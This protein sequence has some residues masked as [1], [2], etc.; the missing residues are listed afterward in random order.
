M[1][2]TAQNLMANV[3]DYQY[4]H[5]HPVTHDGYS[6]P[7][8]PFG[9]SNAQHTYSPTDHNGP[10]SFYYYSRKKEATSSST[11]PS[12]DLLDPN[13]G[14]FE[15]TLS[16]IAP[17]PSC[18]SST[19]ESPTYPTF[20]NHT[21]PPAYA[22]NPNF[23]SYTAE[24]YKKRPRGTT[25]TIVCDE[26]G[27][28][29]TVAASLYRH[30]RTSHGKKPTKKTPSTRRKITKA[31]DV[32][33]TTAYNDPPSS[34]IRSTLEPLQDGSLF[35]RLD[36]NSFNLSAAS[37]PI[38]SPGAE[39]ATSVLDP[40]KITSYNQQPHSTM[41]YVP[42]PQDTSADH[43]I[44][45]CDLCP[46]RFERR[47]ILQTHKAWTHNLTEIGYLPDIGAIDLPP[48]LI[49]VMPNMGSKHTR[50]ALRAFEHGGLSSSPCQPCLLKGIDCIVSPF[51]SSKCCYC[52]HQGHR[53]YCGAS[54]VKWA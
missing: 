32:R 30:S 43:K 3:S 31:K 48:Y 28:K 41:S 35:G 45:F 2:F 20:T 18:L 23:V 19:T 24:P 1:A 47:D 13:S 14:L 17:A 54:G 21:L 38:D 9:A 50:A 46:G 27:K 10:H 29:F 6:G 15:P 51:T 49:G 37:T 4:P 26:C 7:F 44:F 53:G 36:S 16:R 11:V 52:I 39:H 25:G 40:G 42:R 5:P 8:P 22:T 33:L 34:V 12:H